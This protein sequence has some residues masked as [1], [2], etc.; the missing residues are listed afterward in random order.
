MT[1]ILDIWVPGVPRPKGSM[2]HVGK[3]RMRQSVRGSTE[4]AGVMRR[5]VVD[6][7]AHGR[8]GFAERS[9]PVHV[10][11]VFWVPTEHI[12][13][14]R[15]GDVDKLTRNVLDALTGV[16]YVDD[17]QVVWIDAWRLPATGW[18]AGTHVVV[19]TASDAP[20]G[21]QR[22]LAARASFAYREATDPTFRH[23][24]GAQLGHDCF[25]MDC[26]PV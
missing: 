13:A 14:E 21:H 22:M 26:G 11:C 8:A 1:K 7:K 18:G 25:A 5:A 24:A 17:V 6:A 16:V 2:E 20:L 10:Q 3:G 23:A 4:W 12:V 9:T 15:S 19:M